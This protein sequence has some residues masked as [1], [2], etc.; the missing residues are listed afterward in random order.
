MSRFVELFSGGP[1]LIGTTIWGQLLKEYKCAGLRLLHATSLY[2]W[3]DSEKRH[4]LKYGEP[5]NGA[6]RAAVPRAR[7]RSAAP[8]VGHHGHSTAPR[9]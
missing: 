2:D 9:R 8:V 4:S 6:K 5:R 7:Q 1:Q 3:S